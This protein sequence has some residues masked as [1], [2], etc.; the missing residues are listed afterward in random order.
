MFVYES[1]ADKVIASRFLPLSVVSFS[2]P[3][4][5]QKSCPNRLEFAK[6]EMHE[7]LALPKSVHINRTGS[8]EK[9][10]REGGEEMERVI[11]TRFAFARLIKT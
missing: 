8:G 11:N 2:T 5:T 3:R 1:R 4:I 9:G 6:K 7:A 10:E